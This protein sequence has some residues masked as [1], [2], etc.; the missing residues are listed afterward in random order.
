MVG[1]KDGKNGNMSDSLTAFP[2]RI[3]KSIV[4]PGC[5]AIGGRHTTY[6]R[7]SATTWPA[8]DLEQR[9]DTERMMVALMCSGK[10]TGGATGKAGVKSKRE[11]KGKG[12]V[13]VVGDEESDN[14]V[15]LETKAVDTEEKADVG[16]MEH[17]DVNAGRTTVGRRR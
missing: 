12:G 17:M 7:G 2:P 3:G 10:G 11:V 16:T 6:A 1:H 9:A 8:A 14:A 4:C 15:G 5:G 13:D